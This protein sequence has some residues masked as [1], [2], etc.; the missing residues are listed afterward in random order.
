MSSWKPRD[1]QR[2]MSEESITQRE[3]EFNPG[4][5]PGNSRS[6]VPSIRSLKALIDHVTGKDTEPTKREDSGLAEIWPYPFLAIV[7]QKEMKLGLVLSLV[8]PAIGGVL[9]IGPRGTGKTTAVRSLIDLLPAVWHSNCYYG[10]LEEDILRGGKEA[11]CPD[12]LVKFEKGE[13]LGRLEPVRM[14]ELPLNADLED[15]VGSINPRAAM[16]DRMNIR[17][18]ILSYADK[19]ILYVD[20]VNLLSDGVVDAILDASAQGRFTVRRGPVSATYRSRFTLIGTMNPEEG[21]LRP[22]I[23]DRFGLRLMVKGL[24]EPDQRMEAYRR[25]ASYNSNPESLIESYAE[26]TLFARDEVQAAR[27]LLPEIMI[28][29]EVAALGLELIRN[30]DISS[31]RA[32]ITLFEAARAFSS[33]ESRKEVTVDDLITVAPLALRMRKSSFMKDYF[34]QQEKEES[35]ITGAISKIKRKIK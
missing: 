34:I 1:V 31:L 29:D 24:E 19:N 16:Y 9:L 28:S 12:C 10:C 27:D 18:G 6:P 17:R 5:E 32:E 23:L 25:V 3:S 14:V 7:G 15:V 30:F 26:D 2:I 13:P 11:V 33:L 20:E 21:N 8:N 22:Q 35:Q 4:Q